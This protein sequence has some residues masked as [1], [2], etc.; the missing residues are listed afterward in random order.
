VASGMF[1]LPPIKPAGS[2]KGKGGGAEFG[3][4]L[5]LTRRLTLTRRLKGVGG[6]EGDDDAGGG[7][8]GK[9]PG[10]KKE[11]KRKKDKGDKEAKSAKKAKK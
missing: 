3:A 1:V 5:P 7:D 9:T 8:G 4:A 2:S 11:K 10:E 6:G